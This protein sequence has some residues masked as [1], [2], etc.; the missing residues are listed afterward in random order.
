M[1]ERFPSS[2]H[3]RS[4]YIGAAVITVHGEDVAVEAELKGYREPIDGV[5]RWMGRVSANQRLTSALDEHKRIR[6]RITTDHG[7]QE[8]WIGD[9]DP[10]GR[11]RVTG[12]STP[13]FAV[14]SALIAESGLS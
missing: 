14:P 6:V 2:P 9:P 7:S 3:A 13:P 8:A 1:S 5:Y 11:L 10:W 4:N 12:K